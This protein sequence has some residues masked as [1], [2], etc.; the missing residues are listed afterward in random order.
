MSHNVRNVTIEDTDQSLPAP[1]TTLVSNPDHPHAIH[2]LFTA[3]DGAGYAIAGDDDT[4]LVSLTAQ[5]FDGDGK[6]DR[7]TIVVD[8]TFVWTLYAR[9]TETVTVLVGHG[10]NQEEVTEERVTYIPVAEYTGMPL[11]IDFDLLGFRVLQFALR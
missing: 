6:S 3:A 2:Y 10:K 7:R 4:G 5:D 9:T 8:P 1:G 11:E